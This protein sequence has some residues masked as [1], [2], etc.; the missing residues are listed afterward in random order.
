MIPKPTSEVWL[1]CALRENPYQGCAALEGRSGSPHSPHSLKS[2][3][4]KRLGH[5][6]T[7]DDLCDLVTNGKIDHR[8]I[9]M[10]SFNAFRERLEAVL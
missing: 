2:E 1:L 8:R 5:Q 10:P 9:D 6:A 7:R 4:E 3:L